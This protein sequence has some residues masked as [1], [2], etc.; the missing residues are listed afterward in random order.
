MP[1]SYHNFVKKLR[2]IYL[3]I[4]GEDAIIGESDRLKLIGANL[5]IKDFYK[6]ID[7]ECSV[8]EYENF[9]RELF[10][11]K[12]NIGRE[13]SSISFDEAK[14][15]IYPRIYNTNIFKQY[16]HLPYSEWMD[17]NIITYVI[18]SND[19]TS[20]IDLVMIEKWRISL[21][22]LHEI[23]IKNL[24][25]I[26]KIDMDDKNNI[27][28]NINNCVVNIS[29]KDSYDSARILLTNLIYPQASTLLKSAEFNCAIP[30]RDAFILW[31]D[32]QNSGLTSA[33]QNMIDRSYK[34]LSYPISTRVFRMNR[35]GVYIPTPP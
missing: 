26:T 4:H 23:A 3:E 35:D 20:S 18:D 24:E 12:S 34:D 25:E 30:N 19:T 16:V 28:L 13:V 5:S 10:I 9:I 1:L 33:I 6:S 31:A 32:T 7:A 8:D 11:E 22:Y 15:N 2:E 17:E 29:F 14:N 27:I 21:D